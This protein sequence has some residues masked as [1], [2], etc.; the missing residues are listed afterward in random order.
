M[1]TPISKARLRY[2]MPVEL[3]KFLKK[4]KVLCAFINNMTKYS[5]NVK[6]SGK[7]RQIQ[8]LNSIFAIWTAFDWTS[9]PESLT[10]DRFFWS[11]IHTKW[12][13]QFNHE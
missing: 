8:N 9:T 1:E 2:L 13:N 3:I 5:E 12:I 11:K 4:E 7:K 6:P 10:K